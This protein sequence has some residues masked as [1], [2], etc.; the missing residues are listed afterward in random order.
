MLM[1]AHRRL[2][3]VA[4]ILIFI[5][6]GFFIHKKPWRS[7]YSPEKK[8]EIL[9][10]QDFE[11]LKKSKTLPKGFSELKQVE[12]YPGSEAMKG[13]L[14]NYDYPDFGVHSQGK[15]KLEIFLDNTES[16]EVM[17]QYDLIDPKGNT[18]W[19]LGRTLLLEKI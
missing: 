7:F 14:Q 10:S 11:I 2:K 1:N 16:G 15:Y 12:V 4:A 8:L 13:F 3:F 18:V 17:I 9:W 19:E 6:F 5:W